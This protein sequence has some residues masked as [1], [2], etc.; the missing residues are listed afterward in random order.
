M[1][2]RPLGVDVFN[3]AIDRMKAVYAEGHRVVVSFSAG[4]DSGVTLEVCRI[5]AR[6]TGRLPVEVVMRDE[7]IM[8]PGTYEYAERVARDPEV[9]FTWLVMRQ[10]IVNIFNRKEPYWWVFD[11]RLRPEEWVRQPPSFAQFI[12]EKSIDQMTIPSRFP[13]PPGKNLVACIGLR[14]SESRGRMYGLFSSGGY[15]TK[16]SD[17]GVV[18]ARPIYDWQDSDVWKAIKDNQWDYNRCYD[19]LYAAGIRGKAL[20]VGPPTMTIAGVGLLQKASAA[21]PLWFRK[22]CARLPGVRIGAQFG[23]RAVSPLRRL[24]ESWEECFKRE[25]INEAPAPWIRDRATKAM[26]AILSA[27]KHHSTAPLP[28]VNPCYTCF[29]NLGCWKALAHALYNGDPFSLKTSNANPYIEP[30]FFRKGAGTW[31]GKPTW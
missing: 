13:P 29:A 5:A 16:P 30:E 2:R 18:N 24:G 17:L 3:Q 20:R 15:L 31:G 8:W 4:K 6:E 28:D 14:T 27:H 22:V 21:W 12:P 7:E 1:A 10:P 19:T 25:C 23:M 9:A 26:D 11:E